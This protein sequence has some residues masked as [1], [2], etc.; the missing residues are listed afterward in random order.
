MAKTRKDKQA[1]ILFIVT[2]FVSL[3]VITYFI[4][5]M[6]PD[7]DVEIGGSHSQTTQDESES[8]VKQPI[9]DRL[10]WI[11][12][13]DNMPGVSKRDD[14]SDTEKEEEINNTDNK[15]PALKP[16]EY[17]NPQASKQNTNTQPTPAPQKPVDITKKA[18]PFKMSKVYVGSYQTIEQAIQAQN[19]L[20]ESTTSVSPFV[21]ETNGTYVLQAGSYANSAKAEA[22]AKEIS[23]LGFSTKV[24]QE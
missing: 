22:L 5:S 19:K 1:L 21:K 8:D 16:I 12:M 18:E 11:Q 15:Q 6:S 7:V 2:F 14:M 17:V 13:E 20:M 23:A 9:D 4:K 3:I 24:V 10:R